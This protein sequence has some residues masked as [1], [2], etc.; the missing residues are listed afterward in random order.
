MAGD[1][2][3]NL[4]LLLQSSD[5]PNPTSDILAEKALVRHLFGDHGESA[6]R[7]VKDA[8]VGMQALLHLTKT[9]PHAAISD[10]AVVAHISAEIG[11]LDYAMQILRGEWS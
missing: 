1:S 5:S 9:Q 4:M 7:A 10:P 8:K 6:E 11:R 3:A 2:E